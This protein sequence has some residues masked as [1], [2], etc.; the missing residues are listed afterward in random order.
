MYTTDIDMKSHIESRISQAVDAVQGLNKHTEIIAEI[1]RA[2]IHCF[3]QGGT[4]FVAGNGGSAA[5]ANHLC[6]EL[7][8]RYRTTRPALPAHCLCSDAV[9]MTCIANDFGWEQ[10]FRRQLEAFA[11]FVIDENENHSCNDLLLVLTTS[12]NSAN[13]NEALD[14]ANG[15]GMMTLG[16]L[17]RDGGESISKC[18][19]QVTLDAKDSAAI[20]DGHHVIIH[21]ICE[22]IEQ[23]VLESIEND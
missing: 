12:G 16:L 10:V 3:E 22:S 1:S 15:L 20:Q 2:I 8:G 5:Q 9:A 6:E 7:T 21:A 17:G 4:L 19:L 13:I 18:T 14:F 23:W 11:T